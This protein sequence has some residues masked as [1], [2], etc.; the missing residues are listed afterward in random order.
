[1]KL[2]SKLFDLAL[3]CLP[4]GPRRGITRFRKAYRSPFLQLYP[5]GHFYSPIPDIEE[6]RQQAGHVFNRDQAECPAI[7]LDVASQL[8]LVEALRPYHQDF[9]LWLRKEA[10]LTN[11]Q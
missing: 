2:R 6:V 3:W 9:K 11:G 4:G 10:N 5:P 1:M 7:D 8:A